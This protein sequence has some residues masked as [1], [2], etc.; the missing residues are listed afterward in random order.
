MTSIDEEK[1]DLKI[2]NKIHKHH[3]ECMFRMTEIIIRTIHAE[4]GKKMSILL[5]LIV[6]Q[7]IVNS[8]LLFFKLK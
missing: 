5:F 4:L 8:I 3:N 1:L 7:L 6:S 2:D